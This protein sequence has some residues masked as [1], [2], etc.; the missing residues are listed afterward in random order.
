MGAQGPGSRGPSKA[1][2]RSRWKPGPRTQLIS[3]A[4]G[5]GVAR[6]VCLAPP[7]QSEWWRLCAC[8]PVPRFHHLQ[9]NT[10][11][12]QPPARR[13][14][15]RDRRPGLRFTRGPGGRGGQTVRHMWQPQ[16][17]HSPDGGQRGVLEHVR[18]VQEQEDAPD[19]DLGAEG[20][21]SPPQASEQSCRCRRSNT[22]A[23]P[24]PS[25]LT[26]LNLIVPLGA[27]FSSLIQ[28]I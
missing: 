17:R 24:R 20:W 18:A 9:E 19:H 15:P 10:R 6:T 22:A 21:V 14:P 2:V 5:G 3:R 4:P 26:S 7:E 27:G 11:D 12:C 23:S 28:K 13:P 8:W 25:G 16:R 1:R